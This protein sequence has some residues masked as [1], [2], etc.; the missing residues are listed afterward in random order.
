MKQDL[1]TN[2]DIKETKKEK[3]RV[4]TPAELQVV[5]IVREEAK[6]LQYGKILIEVNVRGGKIDHVETSSTKKSFLIS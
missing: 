2:E 4:E 1:N 5:D 3:A 6:A